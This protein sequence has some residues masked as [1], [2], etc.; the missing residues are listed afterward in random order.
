MAPILVY[1]RLSSGTFVTYP[2]IQGSNINKRLL[3]HDKS[4]SSRI[5][6]H[7]WS[8]YGATNL[9]LALLQIL[10]SLKPKSVEEGGGFLWLGRDA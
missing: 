3:G 4:L 2:A 9:H 8:K 6:S 10:K 1:P 5:G 7:L